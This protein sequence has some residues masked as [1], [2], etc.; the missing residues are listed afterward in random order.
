MRSKQTA[1]FGSWPSPI[2]AEM[3]ASASIRL[4]QT[5]V[6]GEMS[7]W[8]E[9]RPAEKGR[10]LLVA[11]GKDGQAEEVTGPEYNIRSA[12]HE[13]GG[14][15]AIIAEDTLFFSNFSDHKIYRQL[16]SEKHASPMTSDECKSRYADFCFDKKRNRLIFVQED[17]SDPQAEPLNFLSCLNL[18]QQSP[19]EPEILLAG[20]DFFSTPKVSPDGR[21]LAWINWNHPNMPW[22]ESKLWTGNLGNDG[23]LSNMQLVAGGNGESVSQAAWGSDGTLYFISNKSGW[24]NLYASYSGLVE[25]LYEM[26]AE[27]ATPDWVFGLSNYAVLEN[28][29]II[30][31]YN[32]KGIWQL[33]KLCPEKRVLENIETPYKDIAYLKASGSRVIFCGGAPDRFAEIASLNLDTNKL[34]VLRRSNELKIDPEYFSVAEPIEFES[35]KGIA[36]A[37]YYAP[38]N[39][40]FAGGDEELPALLVKSHGGPTSAASSTLSLE[41]QFWTTRGFAVVDVNYGGS[42]GF[43]KEYRQR[44]DANWGVVDVDDCVSAVKFLAQRGK[45]NGKKAA[46][47]GGSAGGYTTLCALAF[48][49]DCFSAGASYYG[50]SDP[51]SLATD[52][53]KFESRYLDRLIGPYPEK[54]NLYDER[55]PLLHASKIKCPVIFFQGL[56]D[57]VVPPSQSRAMADALRKQ[58]VPLAYLEY[59]GEQHGFRQSQTIK[60]SLESELAFY[61]R[62]FQIERSDLPF[63][64]VENEVKLVSASGV[65]AV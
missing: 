32:Q 15:A 34:E 45:I 13:Y 50:V 31:T 56:E 48:R 21:L 65:L 29:Q 39:K 16:L 27:F 62:V 36:Y 11:C 33:A 8:I 19:G 6:Q 28:N 7:Y 42:S 52:T 41:I 43:G 57:K 12:V 23:S 46:I 63:L 47:R 5:Y 38:K 49:P 30:C 40:D 3:L 25:C 64:A 53:H 54:K 26:E 9:S 60:N 37:F 18:S 51:S 61:C 4:G 58:G 24:L 20:S 35:E 17:H 22:D 10:S 2:Q 59:E 1:P 55:S 14:G 44:L